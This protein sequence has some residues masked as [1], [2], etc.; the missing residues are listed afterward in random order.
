M[1]S[2]TFEHV[3]CGDK[4]N[5]DALLVC[6]LLS[7]LLEVKKGY[8][9]LQT[10]VTESCVLSKEQMTLKGSRSLLSQVPSFYVCKIE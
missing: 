10:A 7:L 1:V 4:G 2:L 8:C 3:R 6:L 9:C 5:C